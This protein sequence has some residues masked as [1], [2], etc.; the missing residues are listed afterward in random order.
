MQRG[1]WA[2]SPPFIDLCL[3]PEEMAGI[4]PTWG[5]ARG[6]QLPELVACVWR[7]QAQCGAEDRMALK[8]RSCIPEPV[9]HFA[10]AQHLALLWP[11]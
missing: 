6:P 4:K 8:Q 5:P 1:Q 2:Q 10:S 3:S 7:K 11:L 9:S